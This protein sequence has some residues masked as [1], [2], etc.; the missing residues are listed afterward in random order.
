VTLA[1][2]LL[3]VIVA[4]VAYCC[5]RFYASGKTGTSQGNPEFGEVKES[6]YLGTLSIPRPADV[7]LV[8]ETGRVVNGSRRVYETRHG[9]GSEL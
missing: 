4:F 9:S 8:E 3:V 6:P 7:V 1:I 5:Y 2:C